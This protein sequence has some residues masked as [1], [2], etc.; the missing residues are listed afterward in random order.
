MDG[1]SRTW[2]HTWEGRRGEEDEEQ[3]EEKKEKTKKRTIVP[4]ELSHY[5]AQE[6][7]NLSSGHNHEQ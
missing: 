3:E 2:Q 1:R 4:L 6:V 7:Q 5:H